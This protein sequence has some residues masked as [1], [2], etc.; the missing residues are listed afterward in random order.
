M[1]EKCITI[2]KEMLDLKKIPDS[3]RTE[4]VKISYLC[5]KAGGRLW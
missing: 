1:V 4:L 2:A 5:V 3:L